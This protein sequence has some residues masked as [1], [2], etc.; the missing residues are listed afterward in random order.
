MTVGGQRSAPTASFTTTSTFLAL[1]V[2][3]SAPPTPTAPSRPTRGA[4]ATARRRVRA[5]RPTTPTPPPAPTPS[6][7]TVT[8][9][10]GATTTTTQSVTVAE[11]PNQSPDRVVHRHQGPCW[12]C[13]STAP[14]STDPDGTV[15]A[16]SW[17]WGDG[18]AGRFG[19]HGDPH[20]RRRRHLHGRADRDRRRRCLARHA[21]RAV[22]VVAERRPT[23][24]FTS[25]ATFLALSVNAAG[26]TDAD[27]TIASY[28]W[29]WG[30][31]TPGRVRRHGQPH[32]CRGGHLHGH[33]HR[34]RR[35]GRDGDHHQRR[36]GGRPGHPRAPTPSGAPWRAAGAPPRPAGPGPSAARSRAG[37]SPAAR[38]GSR[39]TP[40]AAPTA[41]LGGVSSSRRPTSASSVTTDKAADRWRPLRQRPRPSGQHHAGL[42][43]QGAVR[44]HRRRGRV[45]HPQP[46]AHRDDPQPASPSPGLTYAAGDQLQMRVQTFGTSPTTV[47]AKV[48]KAGTTEPAAWTLTTTDSHRCPAGGR[49]GRPLPCTSAA[50]PRTAPC[51]YGIDDL[52][53]TELP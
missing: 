4:G 14:A 32:V 5:R 26:S 17:S 6:A 34:D 33:P 24:S 22:T 42:P 8:D 37:R 20:L 9:N 27:G 19:R 21:A 18:T 29:S 44:R 48:W 35:P 51:V 39:S 43:G 38:A 52:T 11:A 30:D 2:D 25:A 46:R 47:R 45:A 41:A 28:S 3:G 15:A 13:R 7:L 50:P 31:G 12:P 16:Y 49:L 23:A 40:A 1:S 10:R 53:V 36:H